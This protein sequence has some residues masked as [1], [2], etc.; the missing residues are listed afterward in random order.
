MK[1][2]IELSE[3]NEGTI[4]ISS[5]LDSQLPWKECAECSLNK[6]GKCTHPEGK[7]PTQTDAQYEID[8]QKKYICLNQHNL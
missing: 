6:N 4:A 5:A 1:I 7:C 8:E 2:E 3:N